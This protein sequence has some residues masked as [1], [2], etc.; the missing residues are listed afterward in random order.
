M[1]KIVFK[2][3]AREM[4]SCCVLSLFNNH[5][6]K[7]F[8]YGSGPKKWHADVPKSTFFVLGILIQYDE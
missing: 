5:Y 8:L 2:S 4:V 7:W 6:N 3:R 1:I